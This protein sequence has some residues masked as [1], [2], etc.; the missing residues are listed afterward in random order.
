MERQL[1]LI[2]PTHQCEHCGKPYGKK[3]NRPTQRFCSR[4]CMQKERNKRRWSQNKEILSKYHKEYYDKNKDSVIKRTKEYR[5]E[6]KE[7]YKAIQKKH[8]QSLKGRY[9]S[10]KNGS[11]ARGIAFNLTFEQF[12][13]F[14]QRPCHYCGDIVPTVG[15]DRIDS[16]H[17]YLLG[18][19][20]SC[21]EHCNYMK[22]EYPKE[23][24]FEH[25]MKILR[26]QGLI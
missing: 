11:K 7:K 6:N 9:T 19:V 5:N 3:N 8:S 4:L 1:K 25:C 14:W 24:F 2:R 10:Y 12:I 21:C 22:L 23:L 15:L 17:G 16:S 26:H 13:T 20:V 18:N